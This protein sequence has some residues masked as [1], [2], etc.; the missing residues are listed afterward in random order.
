MGFGYDA[1]I[2]L[3][4]YHV[5]WDMKV[6]IGGK[7]EMLKSEKLKKKNLDPKSKF[8]IVFGKNKGDKMERKWWK[9]E[10][11]EERKENG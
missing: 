3:C 6:K 5:L 4:N 11:G 9:L 10:S 8:Y 7:I 2:E 1:I